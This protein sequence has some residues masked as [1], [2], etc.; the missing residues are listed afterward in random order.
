MAAASPNRMVSQ[1][2]LSGKKP[3]REGA[4]ATQSAMNMPAGQGQ[5]LVE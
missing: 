5:R 2:G 3:S 4:A 1:A